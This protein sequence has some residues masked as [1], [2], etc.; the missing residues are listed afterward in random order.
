MEDY[1]SKEGNV[2]TPA[3]VAVYR[4]EV[5][6]SRVCAWLSDTLVLRSCL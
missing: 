5:E 3:I 6:I 1:F 4:T 2:W